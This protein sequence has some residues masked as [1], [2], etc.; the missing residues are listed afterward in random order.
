[1]M[2]VHRLRARG[3]PPILVATFIGG[4]MALLVGGIYVLLR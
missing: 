2:L 1:M 3:H 4:A